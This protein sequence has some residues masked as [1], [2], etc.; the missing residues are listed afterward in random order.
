MPSPVPTWA[1]ALTFWLHL[2]ATAT[3]IGS[4]VSINVMVLPAAASRALHGTRST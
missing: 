1:L 4:L 2:L 3:W